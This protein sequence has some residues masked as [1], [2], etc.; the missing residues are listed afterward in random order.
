[1]PT[2]EAQTGL[3]SELVRE[4][5][6]LDGPTTLT[7]SA[8]ISQTFDKIRKMVG[9][10]GSRSRAFMYPKARKEAPNWV[11]LEKLMLVCLLHHT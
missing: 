4:H 3:W 8:G 11:A 9:Y 1:M 5:V 10:S 7:F 6:T 2:F